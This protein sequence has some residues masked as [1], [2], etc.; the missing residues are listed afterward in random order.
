MVAI[1]KLY[2]KQGYYY[3]DRAIK[4]TKAKL[5]LAKF[6]KNYNKNCP[7]ILKEEF[8]YKP[9]LIFKSFFD[10]THNKNIIN[11]VKKI[12]GKKVVL[13]NS[14]I[15]YK[16]KKKFVSFHQ[17]LNYW[18]FKNPNCLTVSLALT[19][20]NIKN[21]CLNVIPESH[22]KKYLHKKKFIDKNNLLSSN[23]YINLSKK[24]NPI[25]FILNPGEFSVHHGNILHGSFENTSD[26]PRVLYA[27]RFAS[28]ENNSDIYKYANYLYKPKEEEKYFIQL[29]KC[30]NNY[31]KVCLMYREILI[32][33][34]IS[35]QLQLKLKSFYFLIYPFK[36][37]ILSK[38]FRKIYYYFLK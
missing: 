34:A 5:I 1:K 12:L 7:L 20:S 16:N 4:A 15:F 11:V 23:Q 36:F 13:W 33:D 35:L 8:F 18:K 26:L 10:L 22:K 17:D 21:G 37:I 9:H 30:K 25:P 27:M 14:L 29:P 2:E 24:Q 6:E 3:K 31:D 38:T 32:K 19:Q 28:F